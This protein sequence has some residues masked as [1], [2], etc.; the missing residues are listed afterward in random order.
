MS[1]KQ[2]G[3]EGAAATGPPALLAAWAGAM[4]T[5]CAI[6]RGLVHGGK[7]GSPDSMAPAQCAPARRESRARRV[8]RC[9]P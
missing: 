6:G 7:P 2:T 5:A 4:C 8:A 1:C 3:N 9:K